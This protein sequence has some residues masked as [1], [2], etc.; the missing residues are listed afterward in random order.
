MKRLRAAGN[1]NAAE[2]R[3]LAAS[4]ESGYLVSSCKEKAVRWYRQAARN[5]DEQAQRWVAQF[6]AL[7]KL[8]QGPECSDYLCDASA[9]DDGPRVMTLRS[10]RYGHFF[11]DLTINGVTARDAVIDTGASDVAISTATAG[12]MGISLQGTET[13]ASTA[14][15]VVAGITK[16]VPQLRVGQ[17][18]LKGVRVTILPNL[19]RPLVGMSFLGRLKMSAAY[20]Q[21]VLS[22]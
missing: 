13:R 15:G 6:E 4:Y 10:G 9:G 3:N 12:L 20:G 5:G 16:I 11:A 17:I 8:A 1:G 7:E 2:Q 14:N 19:G 22:R 18:T 21:M